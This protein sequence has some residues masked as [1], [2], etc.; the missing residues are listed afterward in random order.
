MENENYTV[1]R[2]GQQSPNSPNTLR[3]EIEY[4]K[5][6]LMKLQKEIF[7]ISESVLEAHRKIG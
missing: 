1:A 4:L 5:E 3:D 6:I 7:A 2:V